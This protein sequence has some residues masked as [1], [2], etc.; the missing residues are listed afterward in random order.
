LAATTTVTM[1]DPLGF[2]GF[3][4][5]SYPIS[6]MQKPLLLLTRKD[7]QWHGEKIKN[8]RSKLEDTKCAA[9]STGPPNYHK[10]FVVH[11]S[12]SAMAWEAI[13]L[14][15]GEDNPQVKNPTLLTL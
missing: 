9:P 13:L 5:S 6:K 1:Y 2:I 14:K 4:G 12:A 3:T 8:G 15:E 10:P 7:K 11:T